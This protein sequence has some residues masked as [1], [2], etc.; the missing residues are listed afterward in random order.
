[1]TETATTEAETPKFDESSLNDLARLVL[2]TVRE[3]AEA[4]NAR[5]A[6]FDAATGDKSKAVHDLRN[7]SD[8]AKVVK[9][10]AW[11]E[12]LMAKAEKGVN[13]IDAY[14]SA[15]LLPTGEM[16]AEEIEA[17]KA[18]L[19]D[20]RSEVKQ[21]ADYFLTLPSVKGVE[22]AET[23]LPEIKGARRSVS[24]GAGTGTPKP[25][26]KAIY[27][28]GNLVSHDVEKDG[29]KET[30]STFTDAVK[31]LSETHKVKIE[32]KDLHAGYFE[33]AGTTDVNVAPDK[34]EYVFS[35]TDKDGKSH[36]HTI[37]VT[38]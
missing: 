35:V 37:L 21:G 30:K 27:V 10:R 34:V 23:L 24:S 12:D 8:D 13:E 26:V 14:I 15:N 25:R 18:A 7:S 38:K 28:D 32:T 11:Y 2:N 1:M 20:L 3:S 4:F 17:E 36:N 22:G 6:K 5:Q 9:F 29:K 19:K 31:F 33:T 16:S